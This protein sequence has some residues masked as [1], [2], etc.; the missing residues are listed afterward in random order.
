MAELK[1]NDE[2]IRETA[3]EV[4]KQIMAGAKMAKLY[5]EQIIGLIANGVEDVALRT[6]LMQQFVRVALLQAM[7]ASIEKQLPSI[8]RSYIAAIDAADEFIY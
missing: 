4:A 3:L 8:A 1:I 6:A 2:E 5:N 7:L